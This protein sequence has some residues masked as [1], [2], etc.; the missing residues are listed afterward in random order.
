MGSGEQPPRV[1][2]GL[3]P[4]LVPHA[5]VVT[6]RQGRV[7]LT[8]DI[9]PSVH[10]GLQPRRDRMLGWQWPPD[11]ALALDRLGLRE[12]ATLVVA[13]LQHLPDAPECAQLGPDERDRSMPREPGA[14][15]VESAPRLALGSWPWHSL[16]GRTLAAITRS[17]PFLPRLTGA[18]VRLRSDTGSASPLKVSPTCPSASPWHQSLSVRESRATSVRTT[19][20]PSPSTTVAQSCLTPTRWGPAEALGPRASSIPSL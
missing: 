11:L 12:L 2:V 8:V 16:D 13:P 5:L 14:P 18:A 6:K 20:P 4:T 1:V 7:P 15:S 19:L 17:V 10:R 9:G 3:P